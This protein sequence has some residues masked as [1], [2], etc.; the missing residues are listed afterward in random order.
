MHITKINQYLYP[1]QVVTQLI[2]MFSL[3]YV[4]WV[5]ITPATTC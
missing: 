1:I 2:T 3:L 4:L 5:L